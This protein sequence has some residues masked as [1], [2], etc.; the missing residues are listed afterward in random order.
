MLS[1]VNDQLEMEVQSERRLEQA[2]LRITELE[3]SLTGKQ[4][5]LDQLLSENEELKAQV[6]LLSA[7]DNMV[8]S[9]FPFKCV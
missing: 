1:G 4:T 9:A 3:E 8:S 2:S 5:A 7:L 6:T